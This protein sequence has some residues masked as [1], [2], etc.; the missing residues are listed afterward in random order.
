M[1]STHKS[2]YNSKIDFFFI[3]FPII[4]PFIYLFILYTFPNY[5]NL[6]ILLTLIFLSE[7]HFGATWPFFLNK[8]NQQKILENK[9]LY[10][11]LPIVIIFYSII[12]F[13]FFNSIYL[14]F[15]FAINVFHVTRQSYG[16]CSIYCNEKK[17]KRNQ[18]NLIYFFNLWFF[19][20]GFIRFYTPYLSEDYSIL[21]ISL[22]SLF[23]V[24]VSSIQYIIRFGLT[25]NFFTCFAGVIL[26][27]PLCF[28]EKAIHGILIGTTMHY[29]QYLL[30]TYK[31]SIGRFHE[32]NF[33]NNNKKKNYSL[34]SFFIIIII[35]GASMGLLSLVVGSK[36][37][38]VKS[39][40]LIPLIGQH[41]HFYID[42]LLWRFKDEHNRKVTLKFL[43]SK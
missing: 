42:A 31:I 7:T 32:E 18:E 22:I 35:Y 24:I 6:L 39:L 4:F 33:T 38:F 29:A 43:F 23:L 19:V 34:N 10:I 27:F 14:L 11:M 8:L 13:F 16:I 12:G 26:F 15:F 30:L 9:T 2:V 28:T 37:E 41:L 1:T 20:I 40:I 17:E 25:K 5:E 36:D 21:V 3:R